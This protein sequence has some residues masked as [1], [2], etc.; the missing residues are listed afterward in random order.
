[1]PG[2]GRGSSFRGGR[3][4]TGIHKKKMMMKTELYPR[5]TVFTSPS[6][7]GVAEWHKKCHFGKDKNSLKEN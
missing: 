6:R 2:T 4:I 1:M 5:G 3:G 7:L